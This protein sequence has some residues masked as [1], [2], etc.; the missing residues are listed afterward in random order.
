MA[1]Q[2]PRSISACL[3]LPCLM[4]G[5]C[6]APFLL[7]GTSAQGPLFHD[8]LHSWRPSCRAL[9]CEQILEARF[10]WEAKPVASVIPAPGCP[11][12]P[13]RPPCYLPFA[14]EDAK[15]DRAL[16]IS[17]ACRCRSCSSNP[18]RPASSSSAFLCPGGRG[19]PSFVQRGTGTP[20]LRDPQFQGLL[21]WPAFF[22]PSHQP[23]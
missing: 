18:R 21:V 8:D 10:R 19:G 16:E 13:L 23:L 3:R 9:K 5:S 12:A 6:A 15:G 1:S 2:S 17:P 7:R 4:R 20:S 11:S 22:F 14:L